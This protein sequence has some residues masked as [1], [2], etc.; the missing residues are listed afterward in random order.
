MVSQSAGAAGIVGLLAFFYA[1]YSNSHAAA[2]SHIALGVPKEGHKY[3]FSIGDFGV[4]A[5]EVAYN[6][7]EVDEEGGIGHPACFGNMQRQVAQV[8]ATLA[9]GLKPDFVLSLGDNFYTRGVES[10]EDPQFN[11]SFEEIYN[12]GALKE[13][14]WKVSLGDHDHRG[15]VTALLLHSQRSSRWR[16]P[17]SFYT[18]SHTGPGGRRLQFVMTD[19]VGLEGTAPEPIL[20][21]RRFR[22]DLDPAFT[23]PT[24]AAEQWNWLS[25]ILEGNGTS[26]SEALPDLWVV[27]CHR[28]VLS[29]VNRSRT[30][31]E[32][33]VATKLQELL[34]AASRRSSVLFL[35]GHDHA[36]Q[37]FVDVKSPGGSLHY[38]GNGV[39]GMGAHSFSREVAQKLS[40]EL[41]WK[42]S[43][44]YGFVV[45]EVGPDVVSQYFVDSGGTVLYTAALPLNVSRT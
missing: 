38:V 33:E 25:N 2:Q 22:K 29:A 35:N 8:M 16:L 19:S 23:G 40:P 24:I 27:V 28:P 18:F 32:G 6:G 41:R 4:G 36:F 30:P 44:V 10:L 37:H 31:A 42:A 43:E 17:A 26:P 9:K 14:E 34:R 3:F 39:G 20:Q 13:V 45:H 1:I 21:K 11:L 7:G 15:N 5:C 12:I